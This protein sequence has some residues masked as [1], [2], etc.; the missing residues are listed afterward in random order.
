MIQCFV[1][2]QELH[3]AEIYGFCKPHSRKKSVDIFWCSTNCNINVIWVS[4]H[5]VCLTYKTKRTEIF[6]EILICIARSKE[7]GLAW[8]WQ[9]WTE[10]GILSQLSYSKLPE[11]I[12]AKQRCTELEPSLFNC[13]RSSI[14]TL[15]NESNAGTTISLRA[16]A[17]V[18]FPWHWGMP[19]SLARILKNSACKTGLYF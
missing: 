1:H 2:Y 19:T 6:T 15:F 10:N 8:K 7:N 13:S 11:D 17:H 4:I 3:G 5:T 18:F 16:V 9:I 14:S 12:C